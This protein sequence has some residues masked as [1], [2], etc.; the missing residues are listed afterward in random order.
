MQGLQWQMLV[1]MQLDGNQLKDAIKSLGR[2]LED[3]YNVGIWKTYMRYI[4][5]VR[6]ASP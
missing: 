1:D 5:M 2:C 6:L 3:C 4:K